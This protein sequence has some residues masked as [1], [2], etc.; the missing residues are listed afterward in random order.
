MW[1]NRLAGYLKIFGKQKLSVILLST[2]HLRKLLLSLVYIAELDS[3]N[4]SLLEDIS[5]ISNIFI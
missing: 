1:L 3:S 4:I 2:A 5:T